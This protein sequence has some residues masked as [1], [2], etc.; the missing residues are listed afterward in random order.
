[1]EKKFINK[2]LNAFEC[3]RAVYLIVNTLFRFKKFS[4]YN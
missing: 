2:N 3:F 4:F 1:M